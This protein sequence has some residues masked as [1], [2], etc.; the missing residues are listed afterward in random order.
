M[1]TKNNCVKCINGSGIVTCDGCHRSFCNKHLFEHREELFSKADQMKQKC[2]HF[3]DNLEKD[4]NSLTILSEINH[5]EEESINKIR[6]IAD[7]ARADLKQMNQKTIQSFTQIINKITT[8]MDSTRRTDDFNEIDL[9]K[10]ND[11]LQ[12]LQNLIQKSFPIVLTHDNQPSS[13]IR[14]IKIKYNSPFIHSNQIN[15]K[16]KPQS[17]IFNTEEKFSQISGHATL[18]DNNLTVNF[19]GF[20]SVSGIKTYENGTHRINFEIIDKKHE[21]IFF[22]IITASKELTPRASE[23]ISVY[24]WRDFDR[25]I[26]NGDAQL[27]AHKDKN[28]EPGDKLTLIIDCEHLKLVLLHHQLKKKIEM[29]INLRKC[30]F[31]WKL[32]I[33]SFGE[34]IISIQK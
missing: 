32:I 31:P 1:S 5:W 26:M 30:P 12:T 7:N 28:I 29:S 18:S 22:G 11:E 2:Q 8:K 23:L 6:L 25:I 16:S 24:G 10:W 21:G 4:K 20:S 3:R 19:H 15:I 9:N 34:D 27:E 13:I 33:S 14:F 17:I